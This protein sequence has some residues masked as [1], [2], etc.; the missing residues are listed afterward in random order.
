V[1]QASVAVGSR[2]RQRSAA[3]VRCQA[4]GVRQQASAPIEVHISYPS[5]PPYS[6]L[7]NSPYSLD[8]VSQ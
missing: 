8:E 7:S 1:G 5:L 6:P 2:R 3:G 4:S